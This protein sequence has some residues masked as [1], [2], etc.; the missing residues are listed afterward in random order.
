M[1]SEAVRVYIVGDEPS[2]CIA[3]ARLV[4]LANMQPRTFGS[5]E[6]FLNADFSGE[7]ACVISDVA[8][9]GTS[10]LELPSLLARAGHRVPVIFI[11]TNDTAKT[12]RLAR[13]VGV[14]AYFC[15]SVDNQAL[16]DAIEWEIAK[17]RHG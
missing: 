6:D 9:P 7:N 2:G 10:G 11:T 8:S 13:E 15:K 14:A 5:V 3:Y 1:P 17:A 12:R 16:L 4:R